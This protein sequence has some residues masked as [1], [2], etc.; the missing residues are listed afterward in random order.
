M[1]LS[2][3][4]KILGIYFELHLNQTD[5][6]INTKITFTDQIFALDSAVVIATKMFSLHGGF[7]TKSI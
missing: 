4:A 1:T 6:I 5:W 3:E 2:S 7:L